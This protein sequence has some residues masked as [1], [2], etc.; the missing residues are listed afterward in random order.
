MSFRVSA[1]V[2]VAAVFGLSAFTPVSAQPQVPVRPH[3]GGF[4][5]LFAPGQG[6]FGNPGQGFLGQNAPGFIGGGLTPGFGAGAG[7]PGFAYPG[8]AGV[9]GVAPQLPPSGVVGS[10]NNLGHWY[11]GRNSGNYGHWYPN[12]IANGRGVLG[13]GGGYSGGA[14]VGGVGGGVSGPYGIGGGLGRSGGALG[15][16][17]IGVGATIGTLRR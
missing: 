12:G 6:A 9:Y 17:A 11:G 13:Y 3:Y 7:Y 2:S 1:I 5:N 15:G 14:Y 10:F 4:Q 16:T 8:G